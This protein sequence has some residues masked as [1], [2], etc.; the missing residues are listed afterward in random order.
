MMNKS[1]V[2]ALPVLASAFVALSP[3][4]Q[5]QT[6]HTNIYPFVPYETSRIYSEVEKMSEDRNFLKNFDQMKQRG[7]LNGQTEEKPWGSTF[8][9]LNRG[10]IAD[11][12]EDS[13]LSYYNPFQTFSWENNRNDYRNRKENFHN[14]I[15]EL[16][17]DELAKLAP[18]EKYDLLLGDK[19]FDLTNRLWK[20][21]QAW[22]SMKEYGF[23]YSIDKVGGGSLSHAQ[24]MLDNGWVDFST[25]TPYSPAQALDAAIEARGGLAEHFGKKLVESGRA[26]NLNSA[27][28]SSIPTAR[29]QADNYVIKRKNSRMATW[30]GI[31]DG[32]STAA[33]IMPRPRKAVSFRLP[34]GRELK[35]YPEDI[36]GLTSMLWA[37]ST[38]Q[39]GKF[40]NDQGQN[41]GG[42]IIMQG[43]RCND[44][45]AAKD[46]FGR[47]Y[48]HRPDAFSGK[49][50]PRCVGVHPAI[51]HL[52]MVNILGLQK[53]SFIV[54]RK[55]GAAV[56]NHPMW[57]YEM[58]MFNPYT[59]EYSNNLNAVKVRFDRS[60]D[61]FANYRNPN[62]RY[63]V[64]LK[65]SMIYLDWAKP[66]REERNSEEDDLDVTKTMFY[67]LELD[68]SGNIIGGQWRSKEVGK[69]SN[70][71]QPDFFWVVT[72]DWQGFFQETEQVWKDGRMQN[73]SA[74][75][76][77]STTPP[78]DWKLAASGAHS[79][80]YQ[81][82]HDYG[83][84]EKCKIKNKD[85]NEIVEVACEYKINKPQ[86]LVNVVNKLLELSR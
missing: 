4:A 23:L 65:T 8:W 66:V 15:D 75:R 44:G 55:V 63:L 39:D 56:D 60:R 12:Y 2:F 74:W 51:W 21:M 36:K 83:W 5:A 50:E 28:R 10:L 33:G 78:A 27:I 16:D 81:Q 77:L 82:T 86:P 68:A 67:D 72:K 25:N 20:Y 58:E 69:G 17:S 73:L 37:N 11:A 40:I 79:F 13:M 47:I 54:E 26:S 49:L 6:R 9:P 22:G 46:E 52:G 18:S 29:A 57:R 42:G 24:M 38:I 7:L 35:F 53:R 80:I 34:D 84:N 45:D 59:G 3:Q 62:T 48:D 14:K 71:N 61:Q 31:C 64:G 41:V 70:H 76:D 30:E 43:L 32:W 85:T 1:T 19:S